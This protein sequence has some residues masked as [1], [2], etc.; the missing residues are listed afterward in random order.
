MRI[1]GKAGLLLGALLLAAGA[2]PAAAQPVGAGAPVDVTADEDAGLQVAAG[3]SQVHSLS[4]QGDANVSVFGLTGGDP[5]MNG[6]YIL[7]SFNGLPAEGSKIFRIGDVL[8][9]HILSDSPGRLLM[10][11]RENTINDGGVIGEASRRVLVTWTPG[12]DGAPPTTVR[13]RTA[14]AAPAARRR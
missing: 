1:H 3:V 5:A 12:R 14:P 11:V 2:A 13:V 10:Q 4:H 6:E 7:L 8:E 9:F